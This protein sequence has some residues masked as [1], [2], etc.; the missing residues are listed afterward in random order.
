MKP[1]IFFVKRMNAAAMMRLRAI[2]AV[3]S[4]TVSFFESKGGLTMKKLNLFGKRMNAA[5][6]MRLL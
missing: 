6:A 5:A 4:G 2:I 1:L 3:L